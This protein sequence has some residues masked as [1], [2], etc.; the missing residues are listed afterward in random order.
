MIKIQELSNYQIVTIA[1]TLLGGDSEHIDREDIAIKADEIVSGKF[2]WRKYPNRIDINAVMVALNDAKKTKNGGLIIGNNQRGWMLS[3]NGLRWIVSLSKYKELTDFQFEDVITRV[4][5]PLI[6][7]K[8]RLLSTNAYHLFISGK[9][10]N[11]TK[12]DFLKFTRTNEYFQQKAQ[13]RRF[14][15]VENA[16]L[17]HKELSATWNFLK[18]TFLTENTNND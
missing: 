1:V 2:N 5:T 8:E 7:E 9:K 10:A 17:N 14:T 18:S 15:I 11:I 6:I 12:R 3:S 4:F 16:V 13:E